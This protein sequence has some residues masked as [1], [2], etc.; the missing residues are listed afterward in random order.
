MRNGGG[1]ERK[2]RGEGRVEEKEEKK[3]IAGGGERKSGK[4]G[5][6]RGRYARRDAESQR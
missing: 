5:E 3:T 1:E 4:R 2:G 6:S